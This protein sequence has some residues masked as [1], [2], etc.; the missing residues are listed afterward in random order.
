LEAS[1]VKVPETSISI[2]TGGKWT[3]CVAQAV[4]PQLCKALSSNP[5]SAKQKNFFPLKWQLS[6]GSHHDLILENKTHLFLFLC[7]AKT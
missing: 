7:H 6:Q 2:A 1:L 4:E 3:G 5:H